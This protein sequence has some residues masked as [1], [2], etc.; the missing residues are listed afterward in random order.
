[1]ASGGVAD[2]K[3]KNNQEDRICRSGENR[4]GGSPEEDGE[5]RLDKRPKLG[6]LRLDKDKPDGIAGGEEIMDGQELRA[7]EIRQE[8]KGEAHDKVNEIGLKVEEEIMAPDGKH[9]PL[10]DQDENEAN[11]PGAGD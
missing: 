2:D 1:V 11:N 5:K 3:L 9:P 10:G 4:G 7:G 8:H 6:G